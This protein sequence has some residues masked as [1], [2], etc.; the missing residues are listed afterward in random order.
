M[1][2]TVFYSWQNNTEPKANRNFIEDALERAVKKIGKEPDI[3]KAL[4]EDDLL[5]DKDTRGVPGTPPIVDVIL[6]K[7]SQC[8]VFVPDVTF[9][10]VTAQGKPL[11]NP[12]VMIEYGW[13][14]R[15]I[16]YSRIIAVMNAAYG[17][18][19]PTTLPFNMRHLRFPLTYNLPEG[20]DPE[21]RRAVRAELVDRLADAIGAILGT[22]VREGAEPHKEVMFTTDA[23]TFLKEGEPLV[24]RTQGAVERPVY[25]RQGSRLFLRIMPTTQ[26]EPIASTQ[27]AL[28]LV[29]KGQL[30]PMRGEA[31]GASFGRNQYGA[32]AYESYKESELLYVSEMTQLFLSKEIWGI[33][34]ACISFTEDEIKAKGFAFLPSVALERSFTGTMQ[35]YLSFASQTLALRPP[36]K[37]IVGA[38][39]IKG[40]RMA[41]PSGYSKTP[42]GRME[43]P[44]IIYEGALTDYG[45]S[46]L[47][48][49]R[50]FFE[51]LWKECGLPRP[52]RDALE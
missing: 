18:P 9:V 28:D 45:T 29:R 15:S 47:R 7:I 49:L 24:V 6:G 3:Q 32:V 48:L 30:Q 14:L 50:P 4:R 36:L 52:D 35:S 37:F 21:E 39:G 27:D 19:S 8:T 34:A 42:T 26:S 2:L 23:S 38:V 33:D 1:P 44:S 40:Y 46:P 12:N 5:V 16:G 11:P 17:E 31:G 10:G 41:L 20:A 13:A 43:Q 51:L 25:L 22:K